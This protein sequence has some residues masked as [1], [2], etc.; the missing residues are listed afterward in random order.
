MAVSLAIGVFL[1]GTTWV[2]LKIGG[3]SSPIPIAAIMPAAA[4]WLQREKTNEVKNKLPLAVLSS[5]IG[6]VVAAAGCTFRNPWISYSFIA[7]GSSIATFG[8]LPLMRAAKP[9][10]SA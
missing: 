5:F 4:I 9:L 3:R 2:A 10:S 8:V 6:L 1:A 7:L